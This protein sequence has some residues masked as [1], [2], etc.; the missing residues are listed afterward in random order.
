[1]KFCLALS[2]AFKV[3]LFYLFLFKKKSHSLFIQFS[4]FQPFILQVDNL[5]DR[6]KMSGNNNNEEALPLSPD[7]VQRNLFEGNARTR[8]DWLV[9]FLSNGDR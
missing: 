4:R 8:S 1:M 7:C 5:D 3:P 6:S 9:F 2:F